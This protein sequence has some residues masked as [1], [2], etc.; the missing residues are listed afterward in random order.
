MASLGTGEKPSFERKNGRERGGKIFSNV[1]I[2]RKSFN[3]QKDG[4]RL[5]IRLAQPED[6]ETRAN[7]GIKGT[8]K[9]QAG[10]KKKSRSLYSC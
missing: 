10:K 9:S 5:Q 8:R 6:E 4:Q 7:L 1:D 2:S 3:N